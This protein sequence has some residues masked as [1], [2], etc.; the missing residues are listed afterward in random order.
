MWPLSLDLWAEL[1]R[2]MRAAPT[3]ARLAAA[4]MRRDDVF[5]MPERLEVEVTPA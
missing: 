3:A 5:H 4:P 1:A 2:L